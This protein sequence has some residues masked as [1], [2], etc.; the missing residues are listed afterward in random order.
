MKKL[1]SFFLLA[2][3][4]GWAAPT[5]PITDGVLKGTTSVQAP[6]VDTMTTM[7]STAVDFNNPVN[8]YAANS[9]ATLTYSNGAT[10]G[11]KTV[12]RITADSSTRTITIPS[13]YSLTNGASITSI[14]VPASGTV[15][16]LLQYVTSP[17]TR[18]EI[19]GD[20]PNPLA[21]VYGGTGATT[22]YGAYDAISGAE[23]TVA[24]ASTTNLGAVTSNKVSITGTTTITGFGTVAAGVQRW[25]RFTG[26]LTLTHNAT[27]LI[28]PGAANIKT[29][30]G[31]SFHAVSLGSGN[32]AVYRYQRANGKAVI[33]GYEIPL[34]QGNNSMTVAAAATVYIGYCATATAQQGRYKETIRLAGTITDYTFSFYGSGG[35]AN[36]C[37]VTLLLN[38][39]TTVGST[40]I[41]GNV[42]P[43]SVTVTGLTQAV[44][45]GDTIEVT[46]L[47]HASNSSITSFI[48]GATV[49]VK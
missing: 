17:S 11:K 15:Q 12:L 46:F 8:T 3:L 14:V 47:N 32:W 19:T 49:T 38:G 10:A 9:D 4:T 23:T 2:A 26:A 18:Y 21:I 6:F 24:S 34:R 48:G 16:V 33:G 27:S 44:S 35:G 1:I 29:A 36:N 41:A 37:T 30:A 40:T 43:G 39:V 42:F 7:G 31:D 20:P 5:T 25:G 45:V 13:T 28:L 22:G